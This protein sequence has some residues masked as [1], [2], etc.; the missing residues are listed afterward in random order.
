MSTEPETTSVLPLV[1]AD[2]Q[3]GG[4]L[5]RQ[6]PTYEPRPAQLAMARVV[7]EAIESHAHAV[8]EAQ[9][10]TGKSYGYLL[11]L[12]RSGT[13]AVISTANKALQDQLFSKDIPF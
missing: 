7:T 10:G 1:L 6:L 3:A 9:T 4:T 13:T 8:I 12:I 2:L 5:A 11:P